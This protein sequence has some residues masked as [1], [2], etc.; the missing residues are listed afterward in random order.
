[1]PT[2]AKRLFRA[3]S[4]WNSS[5]KTRAVRRSERMKNHQTG[6]FSLADCEIRMLL[7]YFVG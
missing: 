5:P 2:H 4:E 7:V 6:W 1:M 3:R